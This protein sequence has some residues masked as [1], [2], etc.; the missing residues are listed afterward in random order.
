MID[1]DPTPSDLEAEIAAE[2]SALA[3]SLSDLTR[4]LSPENLV[5]SIGD[6]LRD[7]SEDLAHAVVKGVRENPVALG[8]MG[9]GLAWL[10]L[11]NKVTGDGDPRPASRPAAEPGR[12]EKT[13]RFISDS[14]A[15][16]RDTI[17]EGTSELS[18]IA[19]DRVIQAREKA[20]A[21]QE[22]I[23]AASHRALR[24]GHSFYEENPL[25][26]A[27]G[28]AAAGAALAAALPRTE[29][30]NRAFGARRD[31]LVE[32]AERIWYDEVARA[33]A[34][35]RAALDEMRVMADEAVED[36]PSGEEAVDLA[37]EKL[38]DAGER[39]R[40]RAA[41]AHAK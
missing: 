17:Y 4:Q 39:I 37:E 18:D 25:I 15:E 21:A 11:G 30:E 29:A 5:N 12:V 27:V 13:R 32:E 35:G 33:K 7:Q 26:V 10:M 41:D 38:R 24:R 3:E 19:R 23:E 1:D 16:M 14:A 6:T 40:S 28:L 34:A 31:A 22:K 9:A 36:I 8:L 20:I 2:R